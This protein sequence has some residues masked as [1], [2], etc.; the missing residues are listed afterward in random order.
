M[1]KYSDFI[2]NWSSFH[3]SGGL[4]T[5][6]RHAV[7]LSNFVRSAWTTTHACVGVVNQEVPDRKDNVYF[8]F[9]MQSIVFN[10]KSKDCKDSNKFIVCP[11]PNPLD[12]SCRKCDGRR[13]MRVSPRRR[14]TPLT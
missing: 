7:C 8:D 5:R 4:T 9:D 3:F 13:D 2:F 1:N 11:L 12:K 14:G 6:E 10:K